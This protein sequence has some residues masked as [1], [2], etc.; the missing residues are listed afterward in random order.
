[1]RIDQRIE[2]GVARRGWLPLAVLTGCALAIALGVY[3][4][5]G[6]QPGELPTLPD[7]EPGTGPAAGDGEAL[8]DVSVGDPLVGGTPTPQA[9][10]DDPN[11]RLVVGQ[12]TA[13][14]TALVIVPVAPGTWFALVNEFGVVF[15]GTL[16]FVPDRLRLGKRP[17]GTVL[18]GFGLEGIVRI[19]YD[20]HTVFELEDSW[21]FDVAND[22]SSFF[23]IEPLA[24]GA[25]RLV[26]RNLDLREEHHFEL[27]IGLS[28]DANDIAYSTDFAEVKVLFQ[29]GNWNETNRFYSVTG[30]QHRDVS[31]KRRQ[32]LFPKDISLFESSEVSY[33]VHNRE[34]N[35]DERRSAF[36]RLSQY[37]R[38]VKV[39]SDYRG[40]AVQRR[41]TWSRD[42]RFFGPLSLHRS[43]DG[44]W[45][46]ITDIVSGVEVLDTTDGRTV[47]S[48]PDHREQR[49][50]F[51]SP[52]RRSSTEM[53]GV[54]FRD[55]RLHV[56][57]ARGS[58]ETQADVEIF[59]LGASRGARLVDRVELKQASDESEL[60]F[61][62]RTVLDP[63]SP[64]SCT[65]H[66]FLDKSLQ[67]V[68][69]QLTYRERPR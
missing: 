27:G 63:G 44:D 12:G 21:Q 33:H 15:D 54:R 52:D 16:P 67:V 29:H 39:E 61:A 2:A 18:A 50:M 40:G 25:S 14:D 6:G 10:V 53:F 1:M 7:E 8:P 59:E 62:I 22:G 66:V 37:W 19:V 55:G 69:G 43:G 20:G 56:I 48:Y 30:G 51:R 60:S 49:I 47:F 11:C 34:V 26:V 3:L 32:S 17:D 9:V 41:E 28:P 64:A 35:Q 23:A 45:L 24:G 57:R 4:G 13:G 36:S 38:I 42:L 58:Q 46:A 5:W 65:D 31:I 68:D